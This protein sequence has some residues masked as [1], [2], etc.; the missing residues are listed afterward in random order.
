M[1]SRRVRVTGP[2]HLVRSFP[3]WLGF[4]TFAYPDPAAELAARTSS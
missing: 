1:R 3:D 2:D 4:S